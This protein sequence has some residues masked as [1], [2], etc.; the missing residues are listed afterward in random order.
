LALGDDSQALERIARRHALWHGLRMPLLLLFLALA[1]YGYL[2]LSRR[3][4][5]L[6]RDCRWRLDRSAGLASYRCA[7]CG[8][9]CTVARGKSPRHCLRGN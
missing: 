8:A 7:A 4:S 3:N 5:T 2:W 6:T 1:V 9:E